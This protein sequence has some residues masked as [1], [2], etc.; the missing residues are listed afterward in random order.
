MGTMTSPVT[1]IDEQ[2]SQ[3]LPNRERYE[4]IYNGLLFEEKNV[5]NDHFLVKIL[6]VSGIDLCRVVFASSVNI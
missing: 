1:V 4:I 3:L 6:F 2:Q 5:L